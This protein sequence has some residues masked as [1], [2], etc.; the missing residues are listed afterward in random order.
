MSL[1]RVILGWRRLH[2][3][4]RI[5]SLSI[6]W[7]SR[8]AHGFILLSSPSSLGEPGFSHHTVP[9]RGRE[10]LLAETCHESPAGALS[11]THHCVARI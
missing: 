1:V 7:T 5:F 4:I 10:Y 9:G 6:Q 2:G 11:N 3:T 8:H